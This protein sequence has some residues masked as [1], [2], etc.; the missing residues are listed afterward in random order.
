MVPSPDG[1]P[2]SIRANERGEVMVLSVREPAGDPRLA[3]WV[4]R[5][6]RAVTANPRLHSNRVDQAGGGSMATRPVE[7]EPAATPNVPAPA[8]VMV[9]RRAWVR[10]T[11]RARRRGAATVTDRRRA[12][13]TDQELRVPRPRQ[14]PA[15]L[16]RPCRPRAARSPSR[17]MD[18]HRSLRNTWKCPPMFCT[19]A[20]PLSACPPACRSLH[21]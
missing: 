9:A 2:R 7:P 18:R 15:S 20:P 12:P 3:A 6:P 21:A 4:R 10:A 16:P 5:V 14:S 19:R 13:P 1:A 17:A 8:A 11:A